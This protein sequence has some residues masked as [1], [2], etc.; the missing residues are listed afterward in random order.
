MWNRVSRWFAWGL[1]AVLALGI[2]VLPSLSGLIFV[3]L[4]AA[5]LVSPWL[6][7]RRERAFERMMS[8]LRERRFLRVVEEASVVRFWWSPWADGAGPRRVDVVA[9]Q[10]SA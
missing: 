6:R 3:P 10:R 7:D 4:I 8:A 2:P 1:A 5:L 9:N